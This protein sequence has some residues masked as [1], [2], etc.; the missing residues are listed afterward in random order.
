MN[1]GSRFPIVPGTSRLSDNDLADIYRE[2]DEEN[3]EQWESLLSFIKEIFRRLGRL[4][5]MRSIRML[6]W[7][8]VFLMRDKL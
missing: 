3:R 2:I 1:I 4:L 5:M 6:L 7:L 8:R